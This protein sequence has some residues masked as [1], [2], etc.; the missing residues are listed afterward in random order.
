METSF[1]SLKKEELIE[2]KRKI[3]SDI[4]KLDKEDLLLQE[5]YVKV[6]QEIRDFLQQ[7]LEEK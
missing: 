4:N 7:T 5:E 3:I 2:M 6:L 1:D